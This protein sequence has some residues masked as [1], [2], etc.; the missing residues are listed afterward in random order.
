MTEEERSRERWVNISNINGGF[1]LAELFRP[2]LTTN[3]RAKNKLLH[4]VVTRG[5]T[6]RQ[7]DRRKPSPSPPHTPPLS[8][9]C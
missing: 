9:I 1:L 5:R 3:K 2:P 6:A 8:F 7:L 4:D